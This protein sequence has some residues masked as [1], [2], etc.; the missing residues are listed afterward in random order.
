M[1]YLTLF[2]LWLV[3]LL[4]SQS[5]IQSTA[6]SS[7]KL[8]CFSTFFTNALFFL[9]FKCANDF[10][11]SNETNFEKE[12]KNNL[13]VSEMR[14]IQNNATNKNA[15]GNVIYF[16][17]IE[18]DNHDDDNVFRLQQKNNNIINFN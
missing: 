6:V 5:T 7:G 1:K 9:I 3:M 12:E 17:F 4:A 10:V 13:T 18:I 14:N 15:T 2:T 8:Y 11:A 16:I